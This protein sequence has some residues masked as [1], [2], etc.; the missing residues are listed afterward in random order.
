[1]PRL[2]L[3]DSDYPL[4]FTLL[5]RPYAGALTQ[6]CRAGLSASRGTPAPLIVTKWGFISRLP[7][8]LFSTLGITRA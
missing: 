6:S 5:E 4:D 8:M 2:N 7:W 3:F 1:M